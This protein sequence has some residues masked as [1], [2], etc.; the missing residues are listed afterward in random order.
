[1]RGE[2]QPQARIAK[3][4]RPGEADAGRSATCRRPERSRAGEFRRGRP[5]RIA[6][7]RLE[8]RWSSE[9]RASPVERRVIGAELIEEEFA[10]CRPILCCQT[11]PERRRRTDQT[12]GDSRQRQKRDKQ[13]R[14]CAHVDNALQFEII[15]Q[16]RSAAPSREGK[17][18]GQ[19]EALEGER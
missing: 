17:T 11:T 4:D 6:R 10:A 14:R 5:A 13:S 19:V 3:A 9:S 8:R 1:M 18:D 16:L 12:G 7:P 2:R 15:A